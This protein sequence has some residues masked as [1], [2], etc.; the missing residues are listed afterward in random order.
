[1]RLNKNLPASVH[2]YKNRGYFA[3]LFDSFDSVNEIKQVVK[4]KYPKV[5]KLQINISQEGG[6]FRS[7][8]IRS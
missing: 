3:D 5:G 4:M 8:F 2:I 6:Y 1:M 7:L